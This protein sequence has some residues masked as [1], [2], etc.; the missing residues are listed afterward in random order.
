M[1]T[2]SEAEALFLQNLRWIER[3]AAALCRRHGIDGAEADDV[4]AWVRMMV[5]EDD[6]AVLRRF[7]GE[8]AVT[9]Y[10]TV[11]ISLL[12]RE[13]RIRERGRWRPSAAAQ[14][15]G[16]A[17]VRLET[18]V[19]RD[20][21]R[22]E[23]AARV[24]RSAG[25][26]DLSDRELAVLLAALP[27]RAPLRPVEVGS[28]ALAGAPAPGAADP[29]EAAEA[30]AER[31]AAE[32]ALARAL[33]ALPAADRVV[34]RLRYWEGLSVADVARGLGVPQKPLYRTL[35]RA[36]RQ[37]RDELERAGVSRETVRAVL[38]G[39]EP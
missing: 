16:Y 21:Y 15:L 11:A 32:E 24:L 38:G 34:V 31:G 33:D 29:A 12:F 35:E 28:E 8:S 19:R 14:R 25:T 36:L 18:L 10:L 7:R 17:A 22:L 26:T 3:V 39:G 4:V 30:D 27:A 13:H 9:T 2:R 5:I 23:E 6:Y 1:L 20:G 37:M